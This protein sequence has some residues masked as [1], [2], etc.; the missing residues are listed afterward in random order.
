MK[1]CDHS[2]ECYKSE[3]DLFSVP[4][5]QIAVESG[6]WDNIKPHPNFDQGTITFEIPRD[7]SHYLDLAQTEL[8]VEVL[9]QK[10]T[11]T[12]TVENVNFNPTGQAPDHPKIAPVNNF[13]HSLF[14]QVQVSLNNTEVENTNAHY[15]Y[16]AYIENLLCYNK[17]EKETILKNE[18]FIKDDYSHVASNKVIPETLADT[19]Y[20]KS[21]NRRREYFKKQPVQLK[22]RIHCDIFNMNRYMLN[23][24][25]VTVRLTRSKPEFCLLGTMTGVFATINDCFLRVRRV[26][27]GPSLMLEH[28]R[29]LEKTTAKYPITRVVIKPIALHSNSNRQTLAGVTDGLLPKRV[30]VGFLNTADYDGMYTTNPYNFQN[31]GITD[32]SLKLSSKSVP[33]SSALR[34]NYANDKY[35]EGYNTLFQGLRQGANHI[36][37]EDY[38]WG[39]NFYVFN[40]TPDLCSSEHFN[41]QSVGSLDLDLGLAAAHTQGITALFYLEYDN[42]IEINQSRIATKDY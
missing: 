33:Y 42:I 6:V 20:N 21:A 34:F 15:A 38:K 12:G 37:Y 22:G 28:A 29:L 7:G 39:S 13:L 41:L 40:L 5:T 16:R 8:W 2:E 10:K 26:K 18:L 25:K 9:L 4:P 30:I 24:V 27:V 3:L 19:D 23:S 35:L 31:F 36:Y 14:S 11:D 1:V 32:I 17:E